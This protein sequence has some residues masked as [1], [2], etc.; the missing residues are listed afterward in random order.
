MTSSPYA[1][2]LRNREDAFK[3]SKDLCNEL[4]IPLHCGGVDD[5]RTLG[6]ILAKRAVDELPLVQL[7]VAVPLLVNR[8]VLRPEK[9]D[10]G[11]MN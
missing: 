10:A 9:P 7:A 5:P 3:L 4:R 11:H 2:S 6:M 1:Y 8:R